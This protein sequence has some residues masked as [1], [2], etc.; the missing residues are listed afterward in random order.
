[1]SPTTKR[2]ASGVITPSTPLDQ[3]HA[4]M[5]AIPSAI[6]NLEDSKAF[7][8]GKGWAL[9]GETLSLEILARTLFS[10]VA[11]S[12]KLPTPAANTILSVAYLI[13][14][15]IDDGIRTDLSANITKHLLDSLLPITT[16]IQTKLEEHLK[17]VTDTTKTH[18]DLNDKLQQTQEKLDEATSKVT[19]NARSYSQVAAAPIINPSPPF[20]QNNT[21][22]TFAQ[23]QIRNREAIKARQVLIDFDKTGNMDLD[24][25]DERTLTRK[26]T[27]ALSTVWAAITD[28]TVPRP[29]L[30]SA[31][32][33]RN[34]GLL[35]E[36]DSPEAANW[37]KGDEIRDSFLTNMGSGANIKDRTYQVIVQFAPVQFD[38]KDDESLRQYE[39]FNGLPQGSV[40]KAEWIKPVKD[41]RLDQ[42]IAT[43]RVFHKDAQSA[44]KILSEGAHIF[45]K[46]VIPKKPKREPIRCLRCQRFGHERR[47]CKAER[48]TCGRCSGTHETNTCSTPN[49]LLRCANCFEH[50]PSFDRNCHLFREKC[51]QMDARHPEN[52]LAFYPTDE[53]W[54]WATLAQDVRATPPP[55]AQRPERSRPTNAFRQTLLTGANA[56]PAPNNNNNN[57]LQPQPGPSS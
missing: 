49:H 47:N 16:S 33:M 6:K 52:N 37:L 12:P 35:L 17:A 7:L 42:T 39:E 28:P 51:Q 53:P 18:A 27:D 22:I 13:T 48:A 3:V 4:S 43:L 24:V 56:I 9:P 30:K 10:T 11:D 41:R 34:G 46:K 36:L 8:Y 26:A 2:N 45:N 19:S 1:M 44:N 20:H 14:E 29:T 55:P 15:K 23:I 38:P 50:H 57:V 32:L 54:T 25:M 21:N 5:R 40:M 31:T